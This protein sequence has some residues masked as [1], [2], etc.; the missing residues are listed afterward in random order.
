MST[1]PAISEVLHDRPRGDGGRWAAVRRQ[2]PYYLTVL[3]RTW[4]GSIF[5][6][7]VLPVIMLASFGL[8]LGS[9]VNDDAALGGVDYLDFIAPGI[10]ATSALT[11]AAGEALYPVYAMFTWTKMAYAMSSTPLGA[12]D[13]VNG[14]TAYVTFRV[15]T[16]TV[17]LTI[18]LGL[19]GTLASVGG[20]LLL[21]LA[22]TLVGAAHGAVFIGY[23]AWTGS[24]SAL[25]LMFRLGVI[26]M[27]MFS[28]AFFPIDQLPEVVQVIAHVLP[29]WHGVELARMCST[30]TLT[31]MALVHVA[32]LVV[33]GLAGWWWA[34]RAFGRRLGSQ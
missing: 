12:V 25:T 33:V 11:A 19:F 1:A 29:A 27:T 3:R 31:P 5:S 15:A 9:F 28:G 30:D 17:A 34:R 26:P 13:V 2:V 4:R 32:Y 21:V 7:A 16:A 10:L 23:A 8:G 18:V 24:D 14:V 20:A 6:Y 22:G